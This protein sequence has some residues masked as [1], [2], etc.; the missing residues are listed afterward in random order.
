[1]THYKVIF[2]VDEMDKWPLLITNT[3]N[4]LEALKDSKL[5]IEILA[6]SIAVKNLISVES[7][8]YKDTLLNL[9]KSVQFSACNNSLKALKI[10]PK[11]LYDFVK[12]VPSGVAELTIK[13]H[14]GFSYI[15]P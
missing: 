4:L 1:M 6:N 14:Q 9:S 3:R 15:K 7:N 13:Q 5:E 11:D 8:E 2:H 10:D 12:V